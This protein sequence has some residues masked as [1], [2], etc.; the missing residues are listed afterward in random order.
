[1]KKAK[2]FLLALTAFSAVT[3]TSCGGDDDNA[4]VTPPAPSI[5]GTWF[6]SKDGMGT[7]SNEMLQPYQHATG[8]TKDHIEVMANGDFVDHSFSGSPCLESEEMLKWTRQGNKIT[9]DEGETET[10]YEI[11]NHTDSEL[12]LGEVLS[13]QGGMAIYDITV[14]TRS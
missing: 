9:V 14:F 10:V 13:T 6:Y 5:E 3:I 11:L 8:C 2:L 1:M 4:P 7:T 12:K